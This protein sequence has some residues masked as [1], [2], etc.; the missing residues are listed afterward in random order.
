MGSCLVYWYVTDSRRLS[1]TQLEKRRLEWSAEIPPERLAP[2]R[3][4]RMPEG[5]TEKRLLAAW[6]IFNVGHI[7]AWVLAAMPG[8]GG[9][10]YWL[11]SKDTRILALATCVSECMILVQCPR[12]SKFEPVVRLMNDEAGQEGNLA[13]PPPP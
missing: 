5:D 12:W 11:T 8:M 10:F 13:V 4:K 3:M 6:R 1:R 7:V 2:I 9:V